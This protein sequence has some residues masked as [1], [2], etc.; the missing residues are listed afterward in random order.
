MQGITSSTKLLMRMA[1]FA[2]ILIG[3]SSVL[4][5]IY[6]FINKLINWNHY[7]IGTASVLVGVFF[8]E[9]FSCFLSGYLE[10]TY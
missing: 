4:F 8:L 2:G 3:I 7:P 1:T 6:I 5:S 10:N 9:L